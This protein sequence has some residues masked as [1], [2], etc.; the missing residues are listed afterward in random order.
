MIFCNIKIVYENCGLY[1]KPIMI[2]ND[3]SKVVNKLET[4]LTEDARVIIYD[5]HMFIVQATS[6]H[7]TTLRANSSKFCLKS[8]KNCFHEIHC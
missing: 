1:Y 6:L 8:K 4:S 2:I 7:K 5:C 3:S